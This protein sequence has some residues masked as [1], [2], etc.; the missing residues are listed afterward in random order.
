MKKKDRKNQWIGEYEKEY[1]RQSEPYEQWIAK[2]ERDASCQKTETE[3]GSFAVQ[4]WKV[5]DAAGGK[6]AEDD[7]FVVQSWEEVF[8]ARREQT[9]KKALLLMLHGCNEKTRYVILTGGKGRLAWQAKSCLK[10]YFETHPEAEAVYADEDEWNTE[11][12]KR[13]NPWFK[14]DWSPDTLHSCLYMGNI[15]AMKI[16]LLERAEESISE[17]PLPEQTEESISETPLPERTTESISETS[18]PERTEESISETSLPKSTGR[19]QEYPAFWGFLLYLAD[20]MGVSFGHIDRILYHRETAELEQVTSRQENGQK[21]SLQKDMREN[22]QQRQGMESVEEA[23]AGQKAVHVRYPMA[24]GA[25]QVSVVIPSKDH[26]ELLR[27]CLTAIRET[28]AYPSYEVIVVDNG[29]AP[30]NQKVICAMQE[31]L[32]FEYLYKEMDFNFSEMCNLGAAHAK[33]DVLLFLNDDIKVQGKEWLTILAEQALQPHTGAV[34]AKLYYPDSKMIQHA[35]ITNMKIGPAHKLGGMEDRGSLY[36][37]RNLADYNVLAV[38]AACMAVERKKYDAAGGF[39]EELA[40]AYNDVDFCFSLYEKGYYNLVRNDVA[41]FHYESYSRGSDRDA[42]KEKRLLQERKKLYQRHPNLYGKDP[43]YSRHLVQERLDADYHVE[44]QYE[45]EQSDRY[46]REQ[47]MDCPKETKTSL[48]RKLAGKGSWNRYHLDEARVRQTDLLREDSKALELE[49]WCALTDWDMAEYE[50]ALMLI[51]Q[52]GTARRYEMLDKL[53]PDVAGTLPK[54]PHGAL[55]GFVVR[56][57][58]Q[59]LQAGEY[60]VGY[61]YEHRAGKSPLVQYGERLILAGASDETVS[62][63]IDRGGD[64]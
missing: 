30:E 9:L 1:R 59:D 13:Q 41:L 45:H 8:T 51:G 52:D 56:I 2:W 4:S 58:V 18:L 60:Q 3:D 17:T 40:V 44:M 21:H 50:R 38:T 31:R 64:A 26:P 16:S 11:L 43:F 37:G 55:C 33:G 27:Q 34:G 19:W 49:G 36:H 42:V 62:I 7:R 54:Q 20:V 39:C 6:Q 5:A 23:C 12:Q 48:F 61:L 47:P 28:T 57:R 53:R 63:A 35:G 24:G 32:Q 22:S 10:E 15:I 14:P 25:A 29:S 46:S